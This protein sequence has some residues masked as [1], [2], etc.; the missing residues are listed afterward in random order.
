M[1]IEVVSW[2]QPGSVDIRN[3]NHTPGDEVLHCS[4]AEWV[5]FLAAVKDGEY[6][7]VTEATTAS[8]PGRSD[9]APLVT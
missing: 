4:A 5:E 2:V 8:G 9:A 7:H 1:A 3:S 6:D